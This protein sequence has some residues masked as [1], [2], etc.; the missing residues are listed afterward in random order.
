MLVGG[1]N[2]IAQVHEE[3]SALPSE[4]CLNERVSH[5]FS[6]QDICRCD[7]D[8]MC[9]PKLELL[10][11]WANVQH[12]RGCSTEKFGNHFVGD[13]SALPSCVF[14]DANWFIGW[15]AQT[16]CTMGNADGR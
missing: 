3:G 14:E 7:T 8:R 2:C 13:E 4:A 16:R 6:V 10:A 9:R 11:T 15:D 12:F 5:F 1:I